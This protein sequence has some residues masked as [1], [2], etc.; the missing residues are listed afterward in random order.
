MEDV[1]V[2]VIEE[3]KVKA[4]EKINSAKNLNELNETKAEFL[5]KK[6]KLQEIMSKMREF[7]VEEN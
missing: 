7:T 5:G 1:L 3:L 4:L 2:K 6:S